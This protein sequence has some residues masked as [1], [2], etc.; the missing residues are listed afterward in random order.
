MVF[1]AIR[2]RPLT[3]QQSSYKSSIRSAAEHS[4]AVE[5]NPLQG[6]RILKPEPTYT[7]VQLFSQLILD[8]TVP[9]KNGRF[10][11]MNAVTPKRRSEPNKLEWQ[12]VAVAAHAGKPAL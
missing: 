1:P 4:T 6:S 12:V 7:G 9:Y 10:S 3:D 5:A 8:H 11:S 2:S